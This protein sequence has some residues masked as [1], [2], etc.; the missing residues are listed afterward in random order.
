M[1]GMLTKPYISEI[2]SFSDIIYNRI[3]RQNIS[4]REPLSVVQ[5]R[6]KHVKLVLINIGW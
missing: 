4:A 2:S 5:L 1:N 3:N 6:D